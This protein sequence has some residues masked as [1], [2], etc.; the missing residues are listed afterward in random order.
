MNA[1]FTSLDLTETSAC[2]AGLLRM[3][4]VIKDAHS[5]DGTYTGGFLSV[6]SSDPLLLQ[7]NTVKDVLNLLTRAIAP[8]KSMSAS[9]PPVW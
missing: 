3:V 1:I 2:V 7:K 8:S 4:F 6:F 5:A 9:L